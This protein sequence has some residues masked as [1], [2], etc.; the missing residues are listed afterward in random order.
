[1]AWRSFSRAPTG[2]LNIV[3][4]SRW[5]T[6]PANFHWPS[7][8]PERA[9][10]MI[11]CLFPCHG[12]L[13]QH[14][15]DPSLHGSAGLERDQ[16]V[17]EWLPKVYSSVHVA[18]ELAWA[19]FQNQKCPFPRRLG[20]FQNRKCHFPRGLGIFRNRK[21]HFPRGLG[22]FRNRK[23]HFPRGLG[24]F[25]NRKC[26]FPRGLGT[27]RNWKCHFPRGLGTFRNWKYPAQLCWPPC[28]NFSVPIQ[29]V[30][31]CRTTLFH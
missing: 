29:Y 6:P 8:P 16:R 2:T 11:L 27:F 24:T 12:R 17:V 23:C 14:R 7:G 9:S 28:R 20:T 4:E 30:C 10:G 18:W 5:L 13:G 26:H 15:A 19:T 31:S 3:S 1:M 21:C 25:R 22:I